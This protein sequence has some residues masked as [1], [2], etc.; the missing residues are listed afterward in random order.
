MGVKDDLVTAVLEIDTSFRATFDRSSNSSMSN[1]TLGSE[2][3]LSSEAEEDIDSDD[4]LSMEPK[5]E[6]DES[7]LIESI[8]R[9]DESESP[10]E[11][12]EGSS[13]KRRGRPKKVSSP[14]STSANKIAKGRSKTGCI[15]C[16]RRKKKC[17][18]T[19]P[20]CESASSV[21]W[22]SNLN[23]LQPGLTRI[24]P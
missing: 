18:E 22:G 6:E 5:L 9:L 21:P 15:T 4:D 1:S 17:D 2:A 10:E 11:K 16:R 23:V 19:K 12:Y 7:T 8:K 13:K 14:S 3:F 24:R 20:E